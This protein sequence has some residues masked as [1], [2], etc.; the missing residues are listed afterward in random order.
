LHFAAYH[1]HLPSVLVLINAGASL[2]IQDSRTRCVFGG[3][4]A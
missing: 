4:A 2:N 1:G 3:A